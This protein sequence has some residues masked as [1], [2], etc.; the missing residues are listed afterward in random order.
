MV[1]KMLLYLEY[2]LRIRQ[3]FVNILGN[4]FKFTPEKG[5]VTFKAHICQPV[6][7]DYTTIEF[8][9]SDTGV[10]MSEEFKNRLF[11]PFERDLNSEFHS[12]EGNGLGMS[13]VK[14]IIDMMNGE[15]YVESGIGKG[16]TFTIVL[17]L[18]ETKEN[19]VAS[20]CG[21]NENSDDIPNLENKRVLLVEDNELNREIA[22][23]FLSLTGIS[24][25]QATD[26][27]QAVEMMEASENNYYDIIFM[28]IQMPNMNG[29]EATKAIRKL[30]RYDFYSPIITM[31]AL[32]YIH[33][34]EAGMNEHISKPIDIKIMYKVSEKFLNS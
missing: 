8:V 12:V 7:T 25:E 23:E 6:Y 11:Q 26:G 28:D 19:I 5:T 3:I 33:K 4:A 34:K 18:K 13:I 22:V 29:Y 21:K 10:G 17:H 2:P 1:W 27:K 15:I 31:T 30:N 9:C 24:I 32:R 20:D 16:T 14:N